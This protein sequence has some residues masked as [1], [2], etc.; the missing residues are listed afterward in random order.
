L[1]WDVDVPEDLS[2]TK[3]ALEQVRP[4]TGDS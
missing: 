1:G 2:A 4:T 3:P